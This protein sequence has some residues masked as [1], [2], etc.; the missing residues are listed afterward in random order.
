MQ[1]KPRVLIIIPAYNE[2]TNIKKVVDNL[3]TNYPQY[4]YIVI[5]DCSTDSTGEICRRSNYNYLSL[6]INLGIGG[7]VQTGYIYA[8]QNDYDIAIQMDGDGQHNPEY[9][10]NLIK[11]LC[12]EKFDM[13]IGSRFLEKEGF[14][15][16]LMRRM[17]IN[18]I[19]HVIYLCCKTKI[20]DTTSGFRAV[21]KKLIDMYALDYANDYPEP[22]AI[23]AA[24][25]NGFRVGEIPVMMNERIGGIS[26]INVSRS[27]YYMVKVILALLVQRLSIRRRNGDVT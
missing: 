21:N 7:G 24:T 18:I 19:K 20:S 10:P 13:V 5:N 2:E 16:S 1:K 9:I 17:G 23:V 12:E 27:I 11:P 8:L 22:E 14:Q 26:S 15:T 6:P 3:S 25:L 4:D